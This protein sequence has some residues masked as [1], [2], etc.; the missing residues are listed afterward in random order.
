MFRLI[1]V[2]CLPLIN[3]GI[4]YFFGYQSSFCCCDKISE[5][6]YLTKKNICFA[7]YFRRFQSMVRW[8]CCFGPGLGSVYYDIVCGRGGL[9]ACG[10]RNQREKQHWCPNVPFEG[11]ALTS[12]RV[13]IWATY[14]VS[15][16]SQ[17]G[18]PVFSEWDSA[19]DPNGSIFLLTFLGHDTN[20][21]MHYLY[22]IGAIW[23]CS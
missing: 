15:V 2:F 18:H 8:P 11:L 3:I 23:I 13:L 12:S 5:I 20:V 7:L 17:A 19:E 22:N 21:L 16:V 1:F 10:S 9:F 6:I 4:K 14:R